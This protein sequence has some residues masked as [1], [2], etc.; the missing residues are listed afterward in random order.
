VG[1]ASGAKHTLMIPPFEERM[2]HSPSWVRGARESSYLDP[3]PVTLLQALE[4]A[5]HSCWVSMVEAPHRGAAYV[6]G[7]R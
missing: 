6:T 1:G 7:D 4:E 2:V 3:D 5:P